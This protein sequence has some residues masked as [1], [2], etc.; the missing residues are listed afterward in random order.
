ML[1]LLLFLL[2]LGVGVIRREPMRE[3]I[4][5]SQQKYKARPVAGGGRRACSI[6]ALALRN[7]HKQKE[8]EN[9]GEACREK[10]VK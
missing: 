4:C 8:R 5:F 10:I 6:V 3:E 1:C 7:E 9:T 2:L